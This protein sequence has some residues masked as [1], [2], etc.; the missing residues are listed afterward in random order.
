MVARVI[1][2]GGHRVADE[3]PEQ[4]HQLLELRDVLDEA[5]LDAVRGMR[6]AGI[7]WQDI[8]QAA[9]TTRQAAIMRWGPRL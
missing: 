9:G 6:D 5:I 1:A 3:D 4:L 8:G 2:N 7:T